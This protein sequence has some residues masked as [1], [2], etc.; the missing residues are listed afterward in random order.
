MFTSFAHS[1]NTF[2]RLP[3]SLIDFSNISSS[4]YILDLHL[5][6]S[7]FLL[8]SPCKFDHISQSA[9]FHTVV[10]TAAFFVPCTSICFQYLLLFRYVDIFSDPCSYFIHHSMAVSWRKRSGEYVRSSH[11]S[12][13]AL[14]NMSHYEP[15]YLELYIFEYNIACHG[16]RSTRPF[17]TFCP[18]HHLFSRYCPYSSVVCSYALYS[19][20]PKQVWRMEAREPVAP[21]HLPVVSQTM[22]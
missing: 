11:T 13:I 7:L 4:P 19:P 9:A 14:Q 15:F 5:S 18:G 21:R 16:R 3:S 20:L 10:F 17:G 6:T 2:H 8:K 1:S 12:F 22:T